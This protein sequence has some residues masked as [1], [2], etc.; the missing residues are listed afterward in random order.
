MT[1][2]LLLSTN[3][4]FFKAAELVWCRAKEGANT[5]ESKK[6]NSSVTFKSQENGCPRQL[7]PLY[8]RALIQ[9]AQLPTL[10]PQCTIITFVFMTR[11]I[12]IS[13]RDYCLINTNIYTAFNC[14]TYIHKG[15]LAPAVKR[16]M[17]CT[18]TC[19]KRH[20]HSLFFKAAHVT[21]AVKLCP[22]AQPWLPLSPWMRTDAL[23]SSCLTYGPVPSAS[24]LVNKMNGEAKLEN[25]QQGAN[26][27]VPQWIHRSL[28]LNL[29]CSVSLK[30][31]MI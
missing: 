10:S 22:H 21:F 30:T 13:T 12:I 7:T 4:W 27:M 1:T 6:L 19:A 31:L 8:G 5:G 17:L 15:H 14:Q 16:L 20:T 29:L 24:G 3:I 23:C 26:V 18:H 11:T 9:V 25:V 2:V 28:H